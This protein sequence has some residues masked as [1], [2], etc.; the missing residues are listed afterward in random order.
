[1][2]VKLTKSMRTLLEF[3]SK[4]PK[5]DS[6]IVGSGLSRQL[7]EALRRGWVDLADAGVKERT[8]L[9]ISIPAAAYGI[10]SAGRAALTQEQRN[11]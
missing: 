3:V 11:G 7:D 5:L 2:S 10:S 9:G 1:M 8:A 6:Q 4:A